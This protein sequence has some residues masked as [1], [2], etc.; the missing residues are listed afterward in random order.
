MI[1]IGI[2]P[3]LTGAVAILGQ[4]GAPGPIVVDTPTMKV[5]KRNEFN[6]PMMRDIFECFTELEIRDAHVVIEKV[7]S[8]PK[9]G[10]ASS[11]RFGMGYGLWL[12][13]VVMSR[14]RYT[15]V[16]PQR[17]KKA[18]LNGMPKEKGASRVRAGQLFPEA[19][20]KLVKHHGR[21]D[22]LLLAE[23]GRVHLG[24]DDD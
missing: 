24:V 18:M 17:W 23:Y 19:D 12:G 11:F 16:T 15:L 1:W 10:V 7:H 2:D 3:G 21:A 4:P 9:Q 20:L 6:E 8:M 5:G 13:M 14:L 22:A